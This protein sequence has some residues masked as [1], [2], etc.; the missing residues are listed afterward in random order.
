MPHSH[1]TLPSLSLSPLPRTPLNESI[2]P[3]KFMF[4]RETLILPP[5]LKAVLDENL[6]AAFNKCRLTAA[7]AFWAMRTLND[8][9]Q[10]RFK[11]LCPTDDYL[12]LAAHCNAVNRLVLWR[13]DYNT[14]NPTLA[15]TP[16][17]SRASVAMYLSREAYETWAG[18][19]NQALTK[20]MDEEFQE[21][22]ICKANFELAIEMAKNNG[23]L[24]LSDA[25][26]LGIFF[27]EEFLPAMRQWE[28]CVALLG[29]PAYETLVDE[30]FWVVVEAVEGGEVLV[31]RVYG[32]LGGGKNV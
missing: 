18:E 1:P 27:H 28:R 14:T 3:Q 30:L 5:Y 12:R 22:R 24:S 4:D 29:L 8:Q 7:K 17:L 32:S 11:Y 15:P 6:H 20:Y 13:E 2:L 9:R 31:E 23:S 25:L 10:M 21:H 26:L 19:Y 16:K